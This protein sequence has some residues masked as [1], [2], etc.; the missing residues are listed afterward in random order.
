V[1]ADYPALVDT[2]EIEILARRLGGKGPVSGRV[3]LG[4]IEV[5]TFRPDRIGAQPELTVLASRTTGSRPV[6]EVVLMC[7]RLGKPLPVRL[8]RPGG[9]H[10]KQVEC[11]TGP[12]PWATN[13]EQPDTVKIVPLEWADESLMSVEL[14]P[15][16]VTCVRFEKAR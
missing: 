13:L 6:V 3:E 12:A 2:K 5:E 1:V 7:K 8:A 16:S 10:L 4:K 14:R 9:F 11:L 15:C